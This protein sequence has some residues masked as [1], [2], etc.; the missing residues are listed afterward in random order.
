M[1]FPELSPAASD[2]LRSR[3][4]VPD[5]PTPLQPAAD[6][7]FPAALNYHN[8]QMTLS[9]CLFVYFLPV[10]L[11]KRDWE[12]L[13]WKHCGQQAKATRNQEAD[14]PC[15]QK[16]LPDCYLIHKSVSLLYCVILKML[17]TSCRKCFKDSAGQFAAVWI[18]GF[19]S[20]LRE[21]NEEENFWVL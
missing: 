13:L 15:Q 19:V 11:L 20:F 6:G 7:L 18:W 16:N 2:L 8:P 5:P 17:N 21:E 10:R 9:A 12:D 4:L 14:L 1:R 3:L